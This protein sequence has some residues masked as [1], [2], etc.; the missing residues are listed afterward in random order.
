M[1]GGAETL[2]VPLLE[3]RGKP[4]MTDATQRLRA[5]AEE[6]RDL[7]LRIADLERDLAEAKRRQHALLHETMPE[8]MDAAGVDDIGIAASGNLPSL[9]LRLGGYFRGAILADWPDDRKDRAFRLLER[10][11]AG[12]LI[13]TEV[14]ASLPRGELA[15]ARRLVAA[16]ADMGIEAGVAESVH[17]QTLSSWLK[18]VYVKRGQALSQD[19]LDALGAVVGRVVRIEERD[20]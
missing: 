16:A 5:A 13:R 7:R 19:Q 12:S 6:A 2:P 20:E 8:L 1:A 11:D 18:E 15:R 10:L 17:W 3:L 4:D 9:R 14:I